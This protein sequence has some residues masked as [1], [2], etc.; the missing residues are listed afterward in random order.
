MQESKQDAGRSLQIWDTPHREG[1]GWSVGI[2][3]SRQ[4]AAQ[5][6]LL[7]NSLNDI[8]SFNNK[9]EIFN[10][11]ARNRLHCRNISART[12]VEINDDSV[13]EEDELLHILVACT[14]IGPS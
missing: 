13:Q 6:L 7:E 9:I 4:W 2:V 10:L 12:T 14:L 8:I 5:Y 3:E 1:T 11:C